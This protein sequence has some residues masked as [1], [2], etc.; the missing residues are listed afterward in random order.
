MANERDE[1]R[2]NVVECLVV[3]PVLNHVETPKEGFSEVEEVNILVLREFS[4]SMWS[5]QERNEP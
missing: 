5:T 2:F 1:E 3:F 4:V